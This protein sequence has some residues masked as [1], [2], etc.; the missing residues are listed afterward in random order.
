MTV[1]TAPTTEAIAIDAQSFK[2]QAL[3]F[4]A[5][6]NR[7]MPTVAGVWELGDTKKEVPDEKNTVF[8]P[9]K[10]PGPESVMEND[11]RTPVAPEHFAPGGKY[12]A[13]LKLFIQYENLPETAFAHG[14]GW[15][16]QPDLMVTAGHNVYSYSK[17]KGKLPG[18][19][20]QIKAYAGYNGAASV[21][22]PSVEFRI[23][24]RVVTTSH[25]LDNQNSKARDF[26]LVQFDKPFTDVTPFQ[27]IE[28][29]PA[30]DLVLGVVGYPA[31][32]YDE[33]TREKGGRMH[34]LFEPTKYDITEDADKMLKHYI[35]AE[36][37][38]SGGPILRGSD[39][40]AIATHVYGG[41][42][43]TASLLGR[44][45][46]PIQDYIGALQVPLANAGQINMVP[47][48]DEHISQAN[49]A[50]GPQVKEI[51]KLGD[52]VVA[53]T[54]NTDEAVNG[55]SDSDGS[56]PE[57]WIFQGAE[58]ILKLTEGFA[59]TIG[60][61]IAGPIGAVIIPTIIQG[62]KRAQ[63]GDFNE[64][65]ISAALRR[66]LLA[67][68]TLLAA[69]QR[70]GN[71]NPEGL[72]DTLKDII[73][74]IPS[75]DTDE[76][77]PEG[78]FDLVG[79]PVIR[80][81]FKE[82]MDAIGVATKAADELVNDVAAEITRGLLLRAKIPGFAMQMSKPESAIEVGTPACSTNEKDFVEQLAE[83]NNSKPE[84][85]FDDVGKFFKDAVSDVG[86]VVSDGARLVGEHVVGQAL[87]VKK[88]ATDV[89]NHLVGTVRDANRVV[90]VFG[91]DVPMTGP[92]P[93]RVAELLTNALGLKKP[94][95]SFDES[96]PE[97]FFGDLLDL[98]REIGGPAFEIA[99]FPAETAAKTLGLGSL[100][101]NKHPEGAFDFD[102]LKPGAIFDLIASGVR[103]LSQALIVRSVISDHFLTAQMARP[104]AELKSE[105][106]FDTL[107]GILNSVNWNAPPLLSPPLLSPPLLGQGLLSLQ[108]AA[109]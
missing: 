55:T 12:R 105:G 7:I 91:T 57:F 59:S 19:A 43:N 25:W 29:A 95:G 13:I 39:L 33:K 97:G 79:S 75:Q 2:A 45:G 89:G 1:L 85:I 27:Y 54:T 41:S 93:R 3:D 102:E 64:V 69:E 20:R 98:G 47:V 44:Y 49:A 96:K 73:T 62:I 104:A 30:G 74:R 88:R 66:A 14:T 60:P 99:I 82:V 61:M 71:S 15:L 63:P 37:G 108:A 8:V 107:A 36:G 28:T 6:L 23:A 32:L 5:T 17:M 31:D 24:K 87:D 78:V 77:K 100:I 42:Y 83:A 9:L 46:N 11:D 90:T 34:E 40:V 22:S 4:T 35:D 70:A 81:P 50:T 84:G 103:K 92:I 38:N 21:S 51:T 72:F 53:P 10:N 106:F 68:S 94:E 65:D 58:E 76:P 80:L 67:S 52:N 56:K 18:R 101:S 48:G 109:K 86:H 26:A 16:I